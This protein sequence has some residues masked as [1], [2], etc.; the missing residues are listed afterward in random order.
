MVASSVET[1]TVWFGS[2][3]WSVVA[4]ILPGRSSHSRRA[5]V[6]FL[7]CIYQHP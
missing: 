7:E 2:G 3:P 6:G 4:G 1:G 5:T